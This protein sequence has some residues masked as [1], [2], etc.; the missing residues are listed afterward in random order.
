LVYSYDVICP[1]LECDADKFKAK[2]FKDNYC[3]VMTTATSNDTIYAKECYDF[4][5]AKPTDT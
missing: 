1:K 5:H 2:G 4:S 3:Y